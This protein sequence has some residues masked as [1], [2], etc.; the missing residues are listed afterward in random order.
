MLLI[1]IAYVVWSWTDQLGDYSGDNAFYLLTARHFSPW[2]PADPVAAYFAKTTL[3][4]PLYSMLLAVFGGA[5]SVRIAHEITT[6][7]LI[8]T[9]VAL[10]CWLRGLRQPM[11]IAVGIPLIFALLPGTYRLALAIRSE[12]VYCFF[13]V[14]SFAC[15][16]AFERNGR[17]RWLWT[18]AACISAA[19]LT[20]SVGVALVAAWLAFLAIQ[21]PKR[22]ALCAIG[23]LLPLLF[24][25][26]VRPRGP[27]YLDLLLGAYGDAPIAYFSSH[28]IPQLKNL[29]SGWADNLTEGDFVLVVMVSGA[30][31]LAGSLWRALQGKL[32]G[33]YSVIYL[34]VIIAWPYPDEARRFLYPAIPVLLVHGLLVIEAFVARVPIV[35]ASVLQWSFVAALA[36]ALSPNLIQTAQRFVAPLPGPL[37]A[38][39]RSVYWYGES[40]DRAMRSLEFERA[41]LE[42]YRE[43]EAL[44]PRGDCVFSI[45]PPLVGF[46]SHRVS[47][48]PPPER[49][50]AEQF[51]RRLAST[52]CRYF[53]MAYNRSPS[54]PSPFFPLDR[55]R[56]RLQ[57]IRVWH[58]EVE[59]APPVAFLARLSEQEKTAP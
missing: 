5:E 59:K 39:R 4:P 56:A 48:A 15:V 30:L 28:L 11:A 27:S 8:L 13:V 35:R 20:R 44:V 7:F 16:T 23:T 40:Q 32:D 49:S 6:A 34:A 21:R 45:K 46:L 19:V 52:P 12:N 26:A 2:S 58:A 1:G 31:G 33:L 47:Y 17:L 18:A 10:W 41:L 14:A 42:G 57:V 43:A 22:W 55:L 53:F 9:L 38:H 29:E 51:E 36:F 37:E 3:F 25:Q 50:T 54:F 24:W